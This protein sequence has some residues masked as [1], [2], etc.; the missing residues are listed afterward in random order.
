LLR[1]RKIPHDSET[2]RKAAREAVA[3]VARR[4]VHD[5]QCVVSTGMVDSLSVLKLIV[6]LEKK[7]QI[8]IP[9]EQVQPEDFDSIEIILDTLERVAR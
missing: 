7:L 8:L 9:R 4:P 3:A 5:E 2:I 6:I 1:T